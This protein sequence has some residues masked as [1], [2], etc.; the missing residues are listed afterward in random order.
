MKVKICG[1][2]DEQAVYAA[3]SN[4]ADAIGF[5]F[6][7]SKRKVD[8]YTV[9]DITKAVP[10]SVQKVGVFVNETKENIEEI[11]QLCRLDLIQLHGDESEEF[12][13]SLSYPIIKAFGI[14]SQEDLERAKSY[15][16]EYV[17]LDSPKGKY[18]GG[19]GTSFDWNLLKRSDFP[20]K[21]I[22]A[23]G[24]NEHNVQS[25]LDKVT[26]FMVDVSS[27]VETDGKKDLNKIKRFIEKVKQTEE[28]VE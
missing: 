19:N 16:A 25:L 8:P 13:T 4:G 10:A 7:K 9:A 26:P 21:I 12:A 18:R 2:S 23:G 3:V 22:I 1:L 5:V 24:L 28:A 14:S 15:P 17:L 11:A 20:Q 27:G 6:A